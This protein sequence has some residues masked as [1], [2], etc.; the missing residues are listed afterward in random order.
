MKLLAVFIL[1][2]SF[3]FGAID[4]NKAS[5][6]EL[7]SIKGIGEVKAS[8]IIDYRSSNPFKSVDELKNVKGFNQKSV[9]K[10]RDQIIVETEK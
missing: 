2:I 3:L 7:M 5:K 8:A 10:I 1:M 4:L 9:D 6:E